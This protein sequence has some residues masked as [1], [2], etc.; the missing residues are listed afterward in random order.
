MGDPETEVVMPRL[1][2]DIIDLFEGVASSTLSERD[3]MFLRQGCYGRHGCFW[4][5]SK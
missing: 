1:R 2:S 5:I 4:G 3:I